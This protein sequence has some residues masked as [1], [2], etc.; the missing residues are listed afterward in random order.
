LQLIPGIVKDGKEDDALPI[1]SN[2]VLRI[3]REKETTLLIVLDTT[4]FIDPVRVEAHITAI[5]AQ[6]VPK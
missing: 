3:Q 6:L 5:R 4:P 2:A 1:S